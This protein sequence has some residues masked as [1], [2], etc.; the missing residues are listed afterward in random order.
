MSLIPTLPAESR[1]FWPTISGILHRWK[2]KPEKSRSS[3][4]RAEEEK[5]RRVA[6]FRSE[7]RLFWISA[8]LS[9]P[10]L[11]QMFF[12]FDQTHAELLPRWP[13]AGSR[14]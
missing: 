10:L 7:L 3:L 13:C 5:A 2:E 11:L 14:C 9:L 4:A 1:G 8:A 12:M 6:A